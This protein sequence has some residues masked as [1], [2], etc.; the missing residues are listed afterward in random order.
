[1]KAPTSSGTGMGMDM[2]ADQGEAMHM[3]FFWGKNVQ[4]LFPHWPGRQPGPAA[5]LLA[6]CLVFALAAL[7]EFLAYAARRLRPAARGRAAVGLAR[8]AVHGLRVGLA[9]LVM[10][11][12]MS[13]NAGVLAAAVLG[14]ALGFFLSSSGAVL[15]SPPA[16]D[17][18]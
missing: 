3:T 6:L 13:F 12:V 4:V 15:P 9:Y 7:V 2:D 1:M 17:K 16:D 8:T 10:L 11:A 5:Y 18:S 14:H